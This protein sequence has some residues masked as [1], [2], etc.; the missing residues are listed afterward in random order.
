[1]PINNLLVLKKIVFSLAICWTVLIAFLCLVKFGKLPAI[2]VSEADKYVHFAFHFV[3]TLLW[4]NYIWIK[5][6]S[7]EMKLIVKVLLVS[8]LYGILIEFLQ[9]TLTT[10]RHADIY[11]V[12]ANATGATTALGFFLLVKKLKQ[13]NNSY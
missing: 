13:T 1:M 5:N 4:G 2:P 8:L 9:E 3:F 6:K 7:N 11:D 10:T 12:L